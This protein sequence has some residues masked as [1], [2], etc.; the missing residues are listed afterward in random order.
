MASTDRGA[1]LAL[2]HSTGGENWKRKDNWD[3]HVDLSQW[4]GVKA[5]DQGRVVKLNLCGNNLQGIAEVFSTFFL[6]GLLDPF[7]LPGSKMANCVPL[8]ASRPNVPV[9]LR[10]LVFSDSYV[11]WLLVIV[12]KSLSA[13]KY[14]ACWSA[15]KQA[16]PFLRNGCRDVEMP[17]LMCS[18]F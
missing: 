15:L 12:S 18:T 3:S 10:F 8:L 17:S 6:F 7:D 9:D 1:L 14:C 16:L 2:Y 13:L 5:N 11:C 4:F